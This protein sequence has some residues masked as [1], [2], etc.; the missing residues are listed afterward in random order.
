M[1]HNDIDITVCVF[2]WPSGLIPDM[3]ENRGVLHLKSPIHAEGNAVQIRSVEAAYEKL[4][5][6][7]LDALA[8]YFE[9]LMD[10][11]LAGPENVV[12]VSPFPFPLTVKVGGD[13]GT[14]VINKQTPNKQIWLSS[15][16]RC[17]CLCRLRR[18]NS[19]SIFKRN[20]DTKMWAKLE[21]NRSSAVCCIV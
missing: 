16:T 3:E 9:D 10:G 13:H 11:P 18:R 20:D 6:E 4:A 7:T 5:D 2:L 8:D 17:V 19:S 1:S 21:K 14:Y 15:P 12:R